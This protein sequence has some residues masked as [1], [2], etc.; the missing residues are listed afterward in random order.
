MLPDTILEINIDQFHK[1][2][3]AFLSYKTGSYMFVVKGNAYGHGYEVI[4]SELEEHKSI[5]L[6]GVSSPL[7]ALLIRE[8]TSKR[9][10]ILGHSPE[11]YFDSLS[12]NN[13]IPSI[14]SLQEAKAFKKDTD[15]FIVVDSGFHRLGKAP[16]IEYLEEIKEIEEL[17]HINILGVFTHLSLSNK[18]K[19]LRQISDFE[20]FVSNL[21]EIPF[22]SISDS[23]GYTRYNTK[24]NLYRIGALMFGLQSN[25][26]KDKISVKPIAKLIT[27]I[28]RIQT[29]L[30]DDSVFYMKKI[31]PK[32]TII[33]T[34][35]IG[36]ADGL[37]RRMP[38][39]AYCIVNNQKCPYIE[40]GMDQSLIDVS[41]VD[42]LENDR[43]IIFGGKLLSI[44]KFASLCSTNKNNIMTK[45]S[46]RVP[47]VYYKNKEEYKVVSYIKGEIV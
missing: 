15:V 5:E 14:S 35:P 11:R 7:E 9:I 19:D 41:N 27:K 8:F 4:T 28:S 13:I 31:I 24:E 36:Y 2:I 44:D 39:E 37:F 10:V 22:K 46:S 40:V 16:T 45:I 30:E 32:G 21:K 26:E 1:N 12:E 43:V 25:S 17:P 47:R 38:K 6:I 20:E 23:I 18:E 42:V 34:I 3:E 33:A 29:L